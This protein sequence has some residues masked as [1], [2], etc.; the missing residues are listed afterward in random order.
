MLTKRDLQKIAEQA[1]QDRKNKQKRSY[2]QLVAD[3]TAKSNNKRR[4]TPTKEEKNNIE[5]EAMLNYQEPLQIIESE[6]VQP[7]KSSSEWD[8]KIGDPIEYFDPT[9]SYELTGYRPIT[10]T[11]GLDFDPKVFTVAAD[12]YRKYGKYTQ[13][14][15]G[16][17]AHR[18]HWQEE[19]NRCKNGYTVGKYTLTG[20]N[21]F[22]INYYRLLSVFGTSEGGELREEDFP[23]FI[24]KQYE[25]FHYLELARKTRHDALAFKSRGVGASEIAASN[26]AC[27]YT[28]H[29]A[30]WNIITAYSVNYVGPTLS[31]VWQELDFLNTKTEKAFRH[32]RMKIDT[33]M[34]K[35]ASKV[36]QDHNEFGWGSV[37]EGVVADEPRKLRGNRVYG[38]YFEEAGSNPVLVDTYIQSRALINLNGRRVGSRFIFGTAGDTGP[39]LAGLKS[40]FY[41]PEQYFILPYKHN[42]TKT[43]ETIYSGYFIP[44]FTM[45]FGDDE[46]NIPGFDHRGVVDEE[47]AKKH[48][49][50]VW[51]KIS[52]PKLLMKDKA[53]YCFT[54]EDAFVLEGGGVFDA[55]KLAEQK[56]NIE[57]LKIV[58]KPKPAK[59]I[60]PYN[61][62]L[63]KVDRTQTPTIEF[64]AEGKIQILETP[65]KDSSGQVPS[66]LYVIGV[67][68][69]DA[70]KETSTGQTDV[71]KYAIIVLRRQFGLQAPKIVA[72][73]KERPDNPEEA[74]DTVLKLAEYYNA[75][76]LFEAT[77]ISIFTHFKQLNAL[78]YFLKR[79]KAT[80]SSY[81]QNSNQY[82][83]PASDSIIQ[84]QIE[85]I[86]Q[87]VYDYYDQIDFLDIIDELLRYSVE[88]KRKFDYVAALGMALLANEDLLG[89]PP[90]ENLSGSKQLK[91]VGYYINEYG[92]KQFGIVEQAQQQP[93]S[94]RFG[95]F[96][97]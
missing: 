57:Q 13:L 30:S 29:Q 2:E 33:N 7:R 49:E 15:P 67:D 62:E 60:W 23:V 9:L 61:K 65:I 20:E 16:T 32:V 69:I 3:A 92:Q 55:E 24:A 5:Y 93:S 95:W 36:D 79:P 73:Y 44:S 34:K 71:S 89:K 88:A 56:I 90:K 45:W 21:Y 47:N 77:R 39:N 10:A 25:Y 66:N 4:K 41:E 31:K 40:M 12:T 50:K 76:V 1:A 43:G 22:F 64:K 48:Y 75:K 81:R 86:Q 8:V 18:Q 46:H 27:A 14:L 17:F 28:F 96:R 58:E 82:G 84:H 94:M 59:L 54:P 38:I 70:G 78:N 74:H 35:K 37:I 53:E 6:P 42:Y 83:C 97:E 11:Q 91:T 85:L 68:G 52:D 87:Y 19:F 26:I 51:S 72:A 80:I 63:G